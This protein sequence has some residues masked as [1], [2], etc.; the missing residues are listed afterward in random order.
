MERILLQ[1]SMISS[2]ILVNHVSESCCLPRI[3]QH[4]C[5]PPIRFQ[6]R[7]ILETFI[8]SPRILSVVYL[9]KSQPCPPTITLK[10]RALKCKYPPYFL[11]VACSTNQARSFIIRTEWDES[12]TEWWL[13]GI[14]FWNLVGASWSIW[15]G[16][17]VLRLKVKT[18]NGQATLT[19]AYISQRSIEEKC[20][21]RRF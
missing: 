2:Q 19:A 14:N 13:M 9:N 20:L 5:E 12:S 8:N 17:M 1:K 18:G 11:F 10:I 16:R 21:N 7:A 3:R 4:V 6:S 15:W